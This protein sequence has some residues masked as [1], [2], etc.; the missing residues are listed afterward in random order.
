MILLST[1]GNTQKFP[2]TRSSEDLEEKDFV[3]HQEKG[4]V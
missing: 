3:I 1:M 2:T 4:K